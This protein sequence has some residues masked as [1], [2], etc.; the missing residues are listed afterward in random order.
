[1]LTVDRD[2]KERL[3]HL[4]R[5]LHNEAQVVDTIGAVVH[6]PTSTVNEDAN[7]QRLVILTTS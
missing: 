5:L 4:H 6:R 3:S 2:G 1:M 7:R